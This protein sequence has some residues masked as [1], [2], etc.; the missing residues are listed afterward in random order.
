[1]ATSIADI[2]L[3]VRNARRCPSCERLL[4]PTASGNYACLCMN[5]KMV[6]GASV[7]NPIGQ[8]AALIASGDCPQG[9]FGVTP[10]QWAFIA[11]LPTVEALRD[12]L[13]VNGKRVVKKRKWTKKDVVANG[14]VVAVSESGVATADVY[15]YCS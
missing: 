3:A 15:S 9:S 10:D 1:M 7:L 8:K 11:N 5:S 4:L 6:P 2:R 12:G 13:Y 14:E